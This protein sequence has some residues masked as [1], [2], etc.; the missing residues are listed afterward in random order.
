MTQKYDTQ[1]SRNSL[2]KE[3]VMESIREQNRQRE[4]PRGIISE[5]MSGL[6]KGGPV[7]RGVRKRVDDQIEANERG[8]AY[9][10]EKKGGKK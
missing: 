8:E 6:R 1:P 4:K 7:N 9:E 2:S 5:T 3:A 10:P